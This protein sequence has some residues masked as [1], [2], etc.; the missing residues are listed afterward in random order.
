VLGHS[1]TEILEISKNPEIRIFSI[2]RKPAGGDS[3]SR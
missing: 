3:S 1:K 2:I